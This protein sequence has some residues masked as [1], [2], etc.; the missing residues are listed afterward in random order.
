MNSLS[1]FAR[2]FDLIQSA[3]EAMCS[4]K[5]N[6]GFGSQKRSANIPIQAV[7]LVV[8]VGKTI[9]EEELE[10]TRQILNDLK[11]RGKSSSI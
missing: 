11:E 8:D 2:L 3:S 9:S 7:I 5:V 6:S 4:C 1:C 10:C